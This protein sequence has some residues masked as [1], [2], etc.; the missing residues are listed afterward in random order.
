MLVNYTLFYKKRFF[1]LSFSVA[2]LF[3]IE[4]Q[5]FLR[6]CLIQIDTEALLY[7]VY[8]SLC[9]RLSLFMSSVQQL[10]FYFPYDWSYNLTKT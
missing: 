7:L 5:L 8:L 4:S 3:L 1:Q 9:F 2:Y 10:H 6:C